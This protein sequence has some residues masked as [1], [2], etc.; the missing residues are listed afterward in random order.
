MSELGLHSNIYHSA[1]TYLDLLNNF[2][3]EVN[4]AK[5]I[6]QP[7]TNEDVLMFFNKLSDK[8]AIDPEKQM[9]RSFFNSYYKMK[10]K[11]TERELSNIAKHIQNSEIN[12]KILKEIE[13]L[14]GVLKYQC[15]QSFARMKGIK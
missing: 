14:V 15:A 10:R 1:R 8:T 7:Y 9:L 13:D 4:Y 6:G 3:V 5:E 2:L 12:D 11:N